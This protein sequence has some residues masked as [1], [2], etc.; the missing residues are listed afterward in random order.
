M[1][2]GA[3]AVRFREGIRMFL[4]MTT[5]LYIYI[6][7]CNECQLMYICMSKQHMYVNECIYMWRY[8]CIYIYINIHIVPKTNM[9]PENRP[10]EKGIPN[11]E[12][13]IFRVHV[14]FRAQEYMFRTFIH[15]RDFFICSTLVPSGWICKSARWDVGDW[16]NIQATPCRRNRFK[17]W[18]VTLE[19]IYPAQFKI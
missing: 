4:C 14:S 12:T 19:W 18:A 11:L 6:Y 7:I 8:R 13:I 3:F 9:A 1:T 2:S 15:R 10:L 5:Y 16:C 17:P